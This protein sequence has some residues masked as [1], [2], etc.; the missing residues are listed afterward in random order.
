MALP[1]IMKFKCSHCRHTFELEPKDFQRCPNCF[2]TTSLEPVGGMENQESSGYKEKLINEAVSASQRKRFKG[3]K[4]LV[5]FVVLASGAYLLWNQFGKNSKQA[6]FVETLA[7]LAGDVKKQNTKLEISGKKTGKPKTQVSLS[8]EDLE[9]LTEPFQIEIPR[10]LAAEEKEILEN[11]AVIPNPAFQVAELAMWS[12]EDFK[13]LL[14]KE[15]KERQI[16]LGGSY[17]RGL[18][19]TFNSYYIPASEAYAAGQYELTRTKLIESLRF[20]I[21]KNDPELYRAVALVM[22][23]PFVNDV[24]GKI[25]LLNQ[26]L[27]GARVSNEVSEIYR[28]Y[29]LLLDV[30]KANDWERGVNLTRQVKAS[31]ER[32]ANKPVQDFMQHPPTMSLIDPEIQNAFKTEAAPRLDALINWN[33]LLIDLDLK[34]SVAEKNRPSFLAQVQGAFDQAIELIRLNRL[35]EAQA[36]LRAIDFPPEITVEAKKRVQR[37]SEIIALSK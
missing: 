12:E 5:F 10:F 16:P 25:L 34:E 2:W 17:V 11:K 26:S 14:D 27:L 21:Y 23:R 8:P 18:M 29:E 33:E 13:A 6:N 19:K 30:L 22:L 3:V 24:I 36:K 35:E 32:F 1:L 20:P 31:I 28:D 4:S 9:K 7:P 37:I 15:Q